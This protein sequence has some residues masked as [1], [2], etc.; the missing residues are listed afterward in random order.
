[1]HDKLLLDK[2]ALYT[3]QAVSELLEQA[4]LSAHDILVVG[5]SSS[6]VQKRKIGSASNYDIGKCIYD[7]IQEVIGS[8]NIF[9]AAQCCEHLNRALIIEKSAANLYGYPQ[10]N[11]V[12]QL[13][14]GGSF[15]TAAY[16]HMKNPC[17]VET[18][19]AA[20]GIDIGDT[21]IGM[22]LRSVAVPVRISLDKIG[23]AHLTLARTRPRYIGGS[24]SIYNPDLG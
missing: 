24:R 2:I 16:T 10:V 19:Q 3:K 4:R 13:N 9:L 15:A 11:A 20:A 22:H 18:I 14:A 12:P 21:L 1:M 5:C 8:K 7:S 17:A 23:A 6:E